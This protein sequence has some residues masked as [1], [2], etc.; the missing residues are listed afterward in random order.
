MN[1][2]EWVNGTDSELTT[3]DF[4]RV[5]ELQTG[6]PRSLMLGGNKTPAIVRARHLLWACE[7]TI[8]KI[9]YPQLAKK[10]A[11]DHTTILYAVRKVPGDLVEAVKVLCTTGGNI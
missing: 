11:V 1:I 10:Y 2:R 6:I 7:R 9:S 5:I 3:E 4:L 8:L